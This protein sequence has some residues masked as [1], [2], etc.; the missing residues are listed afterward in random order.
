M[1]HV[2]YRAPIPAKV[3]AVLFGVD[4]WCWGLQRSNTAG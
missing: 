1:P 2:I 4:P 3:S